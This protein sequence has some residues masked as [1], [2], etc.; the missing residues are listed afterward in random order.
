MRAGVAI[1]APCL[2]GL[3]A[4]TVLLVVRGSHKA[5]ALFQHLPC[6]EDVDGINVRRML[7]AMNQRIELLLDRDH[8]LG[9]ALVMKA[10]SFQA[11]Q[12]T[13]KTNVMP[14]LEEYFFE[15]WSKIAQVLQNDFVVEQTDAHNVWLGETDTYQSRVY[16]YDLEAFGEP[17]E[18]AFSG[19]LTSFFSSL[20]SLATA[21]DDNVQK[22]GRE[23]VDTLKFAPRRRH[24]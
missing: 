9:H 4:N 3:V 10:R 21:P 13:F 20:S 19:Q 7:Y 11:L 12:Q 17:S 22:R 16:R 2:A 18:T 8:I 24:L 14:L 1:L 15:D 6:C 5:E 23:V